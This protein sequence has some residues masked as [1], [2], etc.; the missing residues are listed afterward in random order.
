M[1]VAHPSG[2]YHFLPGIEPYSCGVRAAEGF[3]LVRARLQP[4]VAWTQGF[5]LLEAHLAASGLGPAALCAAELRSPAP[6]SLA[7]FAQFN[8][9][10]CARL[11]AWDLFVGQTNPIART[12]VAPVL[13]PPAAVVLLAFSY[14]RPARLGSGPGAA[15]PGFVVAGAGELAGGLLAEDRIVRP[16]ETS[17]EAIAA[18]MDFVLGVMEDRLQGLGVGWAQTTAAAAYTAH[19]PP[20]PA[21]ARLYARLGAAAGAHGVQWVYSRPPVTGIEFEMDARGSQHEIRLAT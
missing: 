12:N 5:E 19:L 13:A 11:R 3:E 9:G 2:W 8:R 21:A 20:A 15:R 4:P 18:K 17:P 7:E 6:A 16:G 10:W 14:V 1:L